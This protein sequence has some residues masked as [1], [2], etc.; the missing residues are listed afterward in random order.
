MSQQGL[1]QA[2]IRAVTGSV[3][4]YEGDWHRLFDLASIPAGLFNERLLRWINGKL[5]ASYTNLPEAQQAYAASIGAYNWAAIGTFTAGAVA[6]LRQVATKS[7]VPQAKAGINLQMRGRTQHFA[8]DAI[9]SLQLE[10]ANWYVSNTD[11]GATY[12][13]LGPGATMTIT[14]AIE[15][16]L[17]GAIT[18]VTFGGSATGTVPDLTSL[19]SDAVAVTI[20]KDAAFYVRYFQQNPNGVVYVEAIPA[21]TRVAN[22]DVTNLAASGLSDNTMSGAYT[23]NSAGL[24]YFPIAIVAMSSQPA[25]LLLGDSRLKGEKDAIDATGDTGEAARSIGTARGY[26]NCGVRGDSAFK[27]L[28]ASTRRQ[29]LAQ[30]ASHIIVQYLQNDVGLQGRTAAQAQAD[31]QALWALFPTKRVYQ[32]TSPPGSTS[33]DVFAT[34]T[35]QTTR[36]YTP[37]RNTVNDYIRTT[38]APLVGFFEVAGAV[39]YSGNRDIWDADGITAKY[40]TDDG[41]HESPAGYLAIAASGSINPLTIT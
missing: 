22:N 14:A 1:R 16:P 32:T 26:I 13:E 18:Q 38:P 12:N 17:G 10:F 34:T 31:L 8:R 19:R 39:A 24:G 15:Y 30:Y 20:P 5:S 33:T 28:A 9:T 2:S 11:S 35:N 6:M 23:A 40:R 25:F 41:V 37:A 4:T 29:A 36:A 7:M 21:V 3:E 27:F